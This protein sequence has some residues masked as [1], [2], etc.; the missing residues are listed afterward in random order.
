MPA[1]VLR[2]LATVIAVT[3][4]V[5]TGVAWTKIRS[6]E[7]GI[8][9]ISTAA[10]GG[11]GDDGVVGWFP[12]QVPA[13]AG[14]TGPPEPAGLHGGSHI[15]RALQALREESGKERPAGGGAVSPA[16]AVQFCS[17]RA[18]RI[19]DTRGVSGEHGEQSRGQ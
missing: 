12:A 19:T 2:V 9:H 15:C 7:G 1:R 14:A 13:P 10:L 11:G 3:I 6:F 18:L 8:N 4:V 17:P 16:P 5:V